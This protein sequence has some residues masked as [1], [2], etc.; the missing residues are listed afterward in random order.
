MGER[1]RDLA[2]P[3]DWLL[4]RDAGMV[5]YYAGSAVNVLDIHDRSLNDRRITQRGWDLD[6]VMGRDPRFVVLMSYR[7]DQLALV[8]PV[9]RRILGSQ[10]FRGRY[11]HLAT[12]AWHPGRHFFLYVREAV[13]PP[14]DRARRR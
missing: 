13:A 12:A 4:I 9:E 6:Y 2:R 8:H 7:G 3:G 10:A 1:I 11:R 5:P 14:P